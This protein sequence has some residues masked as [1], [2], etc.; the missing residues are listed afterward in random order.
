VLQEEAICCCFW[1]DESAA[2]A[3]AAAA[4][5][6]KGAADLYSKQKFFIG[7]QNDYV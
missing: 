1:V 7:T 2:L 6:C 3:V 4:C 5:V